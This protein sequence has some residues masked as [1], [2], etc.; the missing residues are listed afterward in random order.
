[1]KTCIKCG[2]E[3]P[4]SG[5]H[6]DKSTKDGFTRYCGKCATEQSKNWYQKNPNV[7]KNANLLREYGITLEEFENL[8]II[9]NNKCAICLNDFKNSID[10]CVD[11]CHT[12]KKVRGLLCN[13]C[14]RALGLFKESKDSLKSAL[15]YLKKYT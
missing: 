11:H 14:N 15:K 7:K 3:K 1:M 9:Q 6:K 2:E 4:L 10:T 8:K 13:H 5:F 12:T